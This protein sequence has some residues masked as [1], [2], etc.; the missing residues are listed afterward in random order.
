VFKAALVIAAII[1]TMVVIKDG[2]VL[3]EAG[4][5]S[6]CTALTSFEGED[7]HWHACRPGRL[8]GRPDLRRRSCTSH[9]IRSG[10]EYWRCPEVIGT[11]RSD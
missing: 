5:V 4:L 11:A 10:Y 8:E 1:A 7:G 6:S 3:R 9:G 2:R